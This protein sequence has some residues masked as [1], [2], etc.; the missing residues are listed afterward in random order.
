MI[1]N[2]IYEQP[3]KIHFGFGKLAELE[4]ILDEINAENCVLVSSKFFTEKCNE[5]MKSSNK[6]KAVYCSVQPNPLLSG[7]EE[8]VRLIKENNADTV[9]ALGGGSAIDTAKFAAACAY[10]EIAPYEHYLS[11]A[12]PEKTAKIVAIPTTAGTGSEVTKVSVISHGNEKKSIHNPA[13]MPTVC[14]V[15][16]ELT[17]TVPAKTTMITGIDA[18]THAIEA[19]WSINHQPI[20]D[21][22]AIESIKL[23]LANL[24]KSYEIGDKESR[25]NMS[26]ASLLAGLAF[27]VPKTAACHACS[28]PL[29]AH[30]H[31]PHGEACALTLDSLMMINNDSRLEQLAKAVGVEN[32]KALADIIVRLKKIAGLCTTISQLGDVE[33][34]MLAKECQK[35]P[36]MANNPVKLSVEDLK[37]MFINL[38]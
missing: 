19:Y 32:T 5:L 14:I 10:S 36:L 9:I 34:D 13:F 3:V 35:H 17:M 20:T 4:A 2:F 1:N 29:S 11:P 27:A 30:Y 7:A 12:F 6:I 22:L 8:T 15:D 21:A 37:E 33:I 16:P 25:I 24:E 23:I 26:C 31:L 18:F 38:G 28:F